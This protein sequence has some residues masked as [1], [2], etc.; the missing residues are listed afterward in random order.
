MTNTTLHND[1]IN[2]LLSIDKYFDV[3]TSIKFLDLNIKMTILTKT[4]VHVIRFLESTKV[5]ILSFT[6]S[7]KVVLRNRL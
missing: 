1:S 7:D 3:A 4:N 6:I 5:L 2:R